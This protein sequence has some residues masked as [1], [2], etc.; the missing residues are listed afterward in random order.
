MLKDL[1]NIRKFGAFAG[2]SFNPSTNVT[3]ILPFLYFCDMLLVMS[4]V[5][6][7]SGQT[8]ISETFDRL[9]E[10]TTFLKFQEIEVIIEVDGGVNNQNLPKLKQLG[11]NSVVMGN[12]LYSSSNLSKTINEV[13]AL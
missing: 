8:F 11:V 13:K 12:F 5:P 6:G 3:E 7:K 9:K 10:I 4:V 2:L 1:L